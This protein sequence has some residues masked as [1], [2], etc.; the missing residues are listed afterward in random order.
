MRRR[1]SRAHDLREVDVF[2]PATLAW[3]AEQSQ[4]VRKSKEIR[5]QDI[6]IL[7]NDLGGF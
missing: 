5:R 2:A 4:K 3:M 7:Y 6:G 1:Q